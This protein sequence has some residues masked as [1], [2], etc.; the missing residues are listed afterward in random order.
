MDTQ[1]AQQPWRIL[2]ALHV[3]C[4][5]NKAMQRHYNKGES[6]NWK[7]RTFHEDTSMMVV[8]LPSFIARC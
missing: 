7:P 3:I 5:D 2:V 8:C 6:G 4:L 1:A